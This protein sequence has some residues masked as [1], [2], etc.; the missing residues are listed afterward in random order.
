MVLKSRWQ[1]WLDTRH[2]WMLVSLLLLEVFYPLSESWSGGYSLIELFFVLVLVAC[3]FAAAD[4]RHYLLTAIVLGVPAIL[5]YGIALGFTAVGDIPPWLV[6]GRLLATV[7]L[8]I[9]SAILI[10]LDSLR[11][12]EIDADKI[13]AA[14][15]VYLLMGLIWAV[16]YLMADLGSTA[17]QRMLDL[18]T[19]IVSRKSGWGEFP[20]YTYFSFVTLSTLGYGDILPVTPTARLL[21]WLEAVFGQIYLAVL[22]ARFVGLHVAQK[23]VQQA[24]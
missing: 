16:F 3:V 12:D 23:L 20:T 4:R 24:D 9:Y 7:I 11:A 13:C 2:I 21:A 18:S 6:W 10:L 14:V 19:E 1:R 5:S 22:I 15:S 8:L 17:E